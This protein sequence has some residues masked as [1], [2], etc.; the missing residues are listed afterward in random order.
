MTSPQSPSNPYILVVDDNADNVDI[1]R[2]SLEARGYRVA[3]APDG[4]RALEMF[5]SLRPSL[6]LLDV[7]MPGRS[8]WDVC[9]VMKQHPEHGRHVR[10]V[11]MTALGA[12]D[13]KQQALQTGA[14][15]Y[16][17]KPID[18]QDLASR[19]QRNLAML[20]AAP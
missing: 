11:M 17:T 2:R 4:D 5:E 14:D 15:D 7:M 18:L 13:D 12:W 6:V 10:V 9:R 19:V 8:G 3:L 16:I 1:V 20:G